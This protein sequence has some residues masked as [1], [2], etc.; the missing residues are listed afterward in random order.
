MHQATIG[1]QHKCTIMQDVDHKLC[2]NSLFFF[3]RSF[4][5]TREEH[6]AAGAL[7]EEQQAADQNPA[8]PN[9]PF[10]SWY[11]GGLYTHSSASQ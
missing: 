10:G 1:V 4:F 7:Q 3:S 2:I 5:E 8:G 9:E 11:C 6:W